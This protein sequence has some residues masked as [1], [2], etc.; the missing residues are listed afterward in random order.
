MKSNSLTRI[1]R[2]TLCALILMVAAPVVSFGQRLVVLRPRSRSRVVVYQPRSY[3][4][5]QRQ[6]YVYRSYVNSY[7][8]YSGYYSYRYSQPYFANRYTYSYVNPAYRYYDYGYRPRHRHN[9]FRVGAW[10]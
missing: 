6:P 5:Y 8:R 4:V 3:A 9:R 7:P 10:R 2:I 1:L